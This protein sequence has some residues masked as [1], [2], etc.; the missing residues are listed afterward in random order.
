[1][2]DRSDTTGD[3]WSSAAAPSWLEEQAE[4]AA[5]FLRSQPY[6]LLSP[7]ARALRDQMDAQ[8]DLR[9]SADV[10]DLATRRAL[11]RDRSRP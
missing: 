9:P 1:M 8:P 3:S 2:S 4:A 6:E 10:I 11:H 7:V 5:Q